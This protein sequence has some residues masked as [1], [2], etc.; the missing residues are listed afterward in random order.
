MNV[1]YP[2]SITMQPFFFRYSGGL[3]VVTE[4]P[5]FR[6]G[7]TSALYAIISHTRSQNMQHMGKL[8]YPHCSKTNRGPPYNHTIFT[9][10]DPDTKS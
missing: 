8:F 5:N 9:D 2:V 6:D 1:I 4:S 7:I 3:I 10:S